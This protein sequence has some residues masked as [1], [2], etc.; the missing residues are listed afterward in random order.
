MAPSYVPTAPAGGGVPGGTHV[1]E[2]QDGSHAEGIGVV[3]AISARH[4]L[5]ARLVSRVTFGCIGSPAGV[6]APSP[7]YS[8]ARPKALWP[9]S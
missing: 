8:S 3:A 2:A 5:V 1:E 4:L 6:P 7:P 9:I